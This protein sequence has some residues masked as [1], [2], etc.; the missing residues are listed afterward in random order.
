M[1]L[2][3]DL[4]GIIVAIHTPF[5]DDGSRID[6]QRLQQHID[7]LIAAGVHGIIPGG[8]TGEFTALSVDERKQLAELCI[9]HVKG[10]VPVIE[11][12]RPNPNPTV[13][14]TFSVPRLT[15]LRLP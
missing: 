15:M 2:Q 5:T 11:D 4:H 1:S 9:D 3:K 6:S 13:P 14:S 8:S 10:R 7:H 12:A